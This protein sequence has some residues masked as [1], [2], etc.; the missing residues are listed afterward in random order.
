MEV[1]FLFMTLSNQLFYI[2]EVL[3][4]VLIYEKS[5]I[6]IAL[7]KISGLSKKLYNYLSI[8]GR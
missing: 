8:V 2:S 5:F 4:F 1:R 6:L 7:T 3:R